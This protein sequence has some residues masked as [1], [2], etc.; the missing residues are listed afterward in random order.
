M[1]VNELWTNFD[2]LNFPGFSTIRPGLINRVMSAT[3]QQNRERFR[4]CTTEDR[5]FSDTH[6]GQSY[7]R[8]RQTRRRYQEGSIVYVP[9]PVP[10]PS[11]L[12]GQWFGTFFWSTCP[13]P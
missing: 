8:G 7:D 10:L 2:F 9:C 5:R 4:D 1:P 6:E 12:A 11:A 13:R 3:T